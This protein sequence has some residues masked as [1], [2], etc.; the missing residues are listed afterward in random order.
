[1]R[2][3][4][5]QRLETSRRR[6]TE[7]CWQNDCPPSR[8]SPALVL[9]LQLIAPLQS[10]KTQTELEFGKTWAAGDRQTGVKTHTGYCRDYVSRAGY[11][12]NKMNFRSSAFLCHTFTLKRCLR[13]I[14]RVIHTTHHSEEKT[15]SFTSL[16]CFSDRDC[17]ESVFKTMEQA[18]NSFNPWPGFKSTDLISNKNILAVFVLPR[19]PLNTSLVVTKNKYWL[20]FYQ[21]SFLLL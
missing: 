3:T 8:N 12:R 10:P 1:M 4:A 7:E 17:T 15:W 6:R 18:Q 13:G 5:A 20:I 9:Q 16:H 21:N 11:I 2:L 14:Y 19:N